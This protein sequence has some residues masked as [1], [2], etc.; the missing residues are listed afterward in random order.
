LS[1][2]PEDVELKEK[3]PCG[4]AGRGPRRIVSAALAAQ[5][6]FAVVHWFSVSSF[7]IGEMWMSFYSRIFLSDRQ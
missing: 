6:A 7:G 5:V 1:I 2:L 3:N 4:I